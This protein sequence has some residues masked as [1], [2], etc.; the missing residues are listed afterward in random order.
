MRAT[1]LRSVLVFVFLSLAAARADAQRMGVHLGYNFDV[2]ESLLGAQGTW[3]I[4]PR[5][6]LYPSIDYYFVDPGSLWGFNADLKFRPPSR[7]GTLY[8]GGGLNY[9]RASVAGNSNSDTGLNVLVGLESRRT[10][11]APYVEAKIILGDG[12]SFQ[13]VGGFTFR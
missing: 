5:V 4:T 12:S 9:T 3:A 6:A 8:V 11:S 13:V 7:G 10:R 1:L 2:E